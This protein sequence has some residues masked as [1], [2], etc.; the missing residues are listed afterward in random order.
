M[1][2]GIQTLWRFLITDLDG[3]GITLLD[4]LA[5][6]R[7]V[8]LK[9]NEASEVT[10]TVPSDSN[11]VNR[12]HT[13]G[14]P[15]LAEGVRQLYCFRRESFLLSAEIGVEPDQIQDNHECIDCD[16]TADKIV[17]FKK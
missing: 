17:L 4:H 3:V 7:M 15:L 6:E 13:D 5:S 10:G 12:L 14:F 16:K 1:P 2:S 9:L 8:T 11:Y